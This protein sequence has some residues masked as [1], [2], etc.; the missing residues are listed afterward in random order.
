M[1]GKDSRRRPDSWVDTAAFLA[2]AEAYEKSGPPATRR[3]PTT[4]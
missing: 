3:M 4:H 2:R 1:M